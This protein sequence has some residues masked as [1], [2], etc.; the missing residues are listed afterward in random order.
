M[1]AS[2]AQQD[3]VDAFKRLTASKLRG[4]RCPDHRLAPR[5]EFHG[6][7]LKDITI[8][9]SGCCDRL[10]EL[11]NRAVRGEAPDPTMLR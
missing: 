1:I 10:M 9:L 6:A 2:Q 8:S 4:L 5:L 3:R 7:A 11:A